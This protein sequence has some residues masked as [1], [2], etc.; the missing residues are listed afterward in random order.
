MAVDEATQT[1]GAPELAAG[2]LHTKEEATNAGKGDAKD[3]TQSAWS[4]E[5]VLAEITPGYAENTDS[6]LPFFHLLE[7]L[8][9]TR[10]A[11]WCRFGIHD[12]ESIS[13]HM[14]RMSII[15][16]MAP[17]SISAT[18]DILRCCQMALIHDM[19][20]ALVGDLTPVDPV[21]K[22]EKS[23]RESTTMDYICTNLLGKFNNGFNGKNV[24]ALWQEYED[25]KTKESIFVHDVDKIEL[26]LQMVEYERSK[27][28]EMDLGEFTWVAEKIQSEEVKGWAV[29]VFKERKQLWKEAGKTPTWRADTEPK[30]EA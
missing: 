27:K 22:E 15:T 3:A 30:D 17:S 18:L 19:A 14:Y 6:P 29:Q 12:C 23:R 21:S 25:S 20:E 5:S 8:K 4:V 28:C 10:R 16:M 11:G 2:K 1:S 26:L 24:R 13:D 7:R 9:T